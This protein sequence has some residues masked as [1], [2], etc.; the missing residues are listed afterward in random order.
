MPSADHRPGQVVALAQGV[1]ELAQHGGL[2]GVFDALG[3][4]VQTERVG[5]LDDRAG[6]RLAGARRRRSAVVGLDAVHER[7]VQL[8]DRGRERAEQTQRRLAGAEVV[9]RQPDAACCAAPAGCAR[10]AG[11]AARPTRSPRAPA[12][13]WAARCRPA[14]PSR[15]PTKSGSCSC[16]AETFGPAFCSASGPNSA[17]QAAAC[18]HV[19]R[20]TYR[21]SG[22]IRP[23][24]SAAGMNSAGETTPRVGWC[25]RTSASTPITRWS[26]SCMIGW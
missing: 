1:P 23:V 13:R 24:R 4:G 19:S 3:H 21:P 6:H 25:Q 7:L 18:R 8:D 14:R 20:S 5:E 2:P 17:S 26:S 15:R 9:Q 11:R 12:G 10:P 16:W 22:T